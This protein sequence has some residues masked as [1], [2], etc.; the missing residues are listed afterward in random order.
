MAY[1]NSSPSSW[2]AQMLSKVSFF[3]HEIPTAQNSYALC[4]VSIYLNLLL[5]EITQA[6]KRK[7]VKRQ[8]KMVGSDTRDSGT[9]EAEVLT[10]LVLSHP[11]KGQVSESKTW[12]EIHNCIATAL[13]RY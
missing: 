5:S 2:K 7:R 1:E 8:E 13:F 10:I 12:G 9:Q 3:D 11:Y 6:H 4:K